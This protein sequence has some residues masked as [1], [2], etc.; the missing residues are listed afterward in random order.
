MSKGKVDKPEIVKTEDG[1][2]TLR[3]HKIP[4]LYHSKHGAIQESMHVF[5]KEGLLQIDKPEIKI[6]EIGFGTGLNALLT[7]MHKPDGTKIDYIAIDKYP[8]E[9]AIWKKLNYPKEVGHGA[10]TRFEALHKSEWGEAQKL[11]DDFTIEKREMDFFKYKTD[12]YNDLIYFDAFAPTVQPEFWEAELLNEMF[13]SLR[14]DGILVT[15]CSK[16]SFQRHLKACG[17]KVEKI[18][19]PPG[20]REMI[21]AMRR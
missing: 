8:L 7:W 13:K 10:K 18:A 6:L 19:G 14:N 3:H 21:R 1:S 16:G 17:F 2:H 20:K 11:S 5:I 15:Y 12:R 9:E 4:E